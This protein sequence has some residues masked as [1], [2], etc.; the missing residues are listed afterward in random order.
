M[1]FLLETDQRFSP[2]HFK[3][4]HFG[5]LQAESIHD[6]MCSL[7][8]TLGVLCDPLDFLLLEHNCLFAGHHLTSS[9]QRYFQVA[10][11]VFIIVYLVFCMLWFNNSI[12]VLLWMKEVLLS[13]CPIQ[14]YFS[15]LS[16]VVSI[17]GKSCTTRLTTIHLATTTPFHPSRNIEL[18]DY[19]CN[20]PK[21]IFLVVV[22]K[23]LKL[24]DS[25]SFSG[26]GQ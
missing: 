2:K 14:S 17:P 1:L 12:N 4:H 20:C 8:C 19:D 3:W 21:T 26:N 7:K 25:G 24:S 5:N 16:Q 23:G 9:F 15:I 10:S 11:K 6:V 18:A 22:G 13:R